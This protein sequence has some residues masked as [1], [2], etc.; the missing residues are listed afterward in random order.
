MK[1]QLIFF[2]FI[3]LSSLQW[4][5]ADGQRKTGTVNYHLWFIFLSKLV[6]SRLTIYLTRTLFTY[7]T[8]YVMW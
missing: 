6:K 3:V 2:S 8:F 4:I 5:P 1:I 7:H